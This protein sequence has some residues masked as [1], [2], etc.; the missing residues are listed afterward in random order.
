MKLKDKMVVVTGASS[1]IGLATAQLLAR[2][3]AQVVMLA[4][5]EVQLAKAAED[6]IKTG[7]QVRWFPVDLSQAPAVE[8]AC[9]RMLAEMGAPDVVV[10]NAGSGQWKPL[11]ETSLDEARRMIEVPYLAGFYVTR[12]LLPEMMKRGTGR[13]VC[14]TSPAS[15]IAWPGACGYI[16]ARHAVKGFAEGL[17]ADLRR[18]GVGV[19]LVTLGTVKSSY[20]Q[21]NP[22]SR[23]HVPLT[24][25]WLMPELST[26]EAASIIVEAIEKERSHVVR[27]TLFRALF[28]LG[29]N[30]G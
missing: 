25:P 16:A 3:G 26:S 15:H 1:G 12:Q 23:D 8:A 2:R 27:P 20:W 14:I 17:R 9:A 18:T 24:I 5:D 29:I 22:G 21:N 10:N 19:T 7:G 4:R 30:P 28:A 13:I 11:L 6:I